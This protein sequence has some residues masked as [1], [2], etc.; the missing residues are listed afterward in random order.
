MNGEYT[1]TEVDEHSCTTGFPG[2]DFICLSGSYAGLPS[3][4]AQTYVFTFG[5]KEFQT[6]DPE[7]AKLI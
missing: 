7:N 2:H 1:G 5:G 4:Q 6:D 3:S